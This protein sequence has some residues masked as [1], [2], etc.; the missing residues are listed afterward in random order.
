M[1]YLKWTGLTQYL[2]FSSDELCIDYY[3]IQHNIYNPGRNTNHPILHCTPYIIQ[4]Y[5]RIWIF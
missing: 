4:M 3:F 1:Y 2:L 5:V